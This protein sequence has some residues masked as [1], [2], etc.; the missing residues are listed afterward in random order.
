MRCP[1]ETVAFV[2]GS[3]GPILRHP[4]V[5]VTAKEHALSTYNPICNSCGLI[6]CSINV[7]QYACPHCATPLLTGAARTSLAAKLELQRDETI[8]RE[9]A[10]RER[11][12]EA[13]KKAEGAF[14]SLLGVASGNV[15]RPSP[16]PSPA[17]SYSPNP[18][19]PHKV[20][21]LSAKK[22]IVSSYTTTPNPSRPASRAEA[23]E[24]P[25]RVPP[26]P[27]EV[28]FSRAQRPA[29]RPWQ[30]LDD[31]DL[32]Y[33]PLEQPKSDAKEGG[34]SRKKKKELAE[35]RKESA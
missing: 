21:S 7:P 23:E 22:V 17:R 30:N 34:R 10:D 8:A 1:K 32:M 26:P 6:L 29:N 31:V 11:A 5:D 19:Q 16:S 3:D 15:A 4:C 18:V 25:V 9:V 13:A 20:M 28:A 35:P 12:I 27:K 33:V 2:H 14:P 24:E